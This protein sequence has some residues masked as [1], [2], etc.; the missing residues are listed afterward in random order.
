MPDVVLGAGS[1]LDGVDPSEE[2]LAGEP[3]GSRAV[4][5]VPTQG[6]TTVI[7]NSRPSRYWQ[8]L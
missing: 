8:L 5:A 4:F 6:S 2:G 1:E 7:S 3:V